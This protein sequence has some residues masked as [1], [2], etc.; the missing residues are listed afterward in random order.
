MKIR[1]HEHFSPR[2]HEGTLLGITNAAATIPGFVGPQVVGALTHDD[3]S[4]QQWRKVFFISSAVYCFGLIVYLIFGS[5]ERQYWSTH[6]YFEE[7]G[8]LDSPE[9]E[10]EQEEDEGRRD[11]DDL[12]IFGAQNTIQS[13]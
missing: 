9:D 5:G 13:E 4:R 8:L 1:H 7:N 10:E 3:P 2:F 6:E 11:D 12:L